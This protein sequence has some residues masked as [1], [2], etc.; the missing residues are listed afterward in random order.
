MAIWLMACSAIAFSQTQ[1]THINGTVYDEQ[2]EPISYVNVYIEGTIEG[3]SSGEDGAFSFTTEA[4]GTVTLKASFIGYQ[5]FSVKDEVKNLHNLKIILKSEAKNLNEVV[6]YAGNYQLKSASTMNKSNAV[7][8]VSTAGSEGD[9]YKSV[10]ML[11][12]T[13][14]ADRDGRLIVRGG[15]SRETQTYIDDMHVLSPYTPAFGDVGSRGRYSPFLF[16]GINF[17]MGGYVPEYSQGLS[18]ILPLYTRDEAKTTKLGIDLM[19]VS[20]GGGGT[21]VWKKASTSFNINYSDMSFYNA[22]FAPS[23]KHLWKKPYRQ[24]SG[25]NQFRFTLGKN[26]YLKTYFGYDHTHFTLVQKAPFGGQARDVNFGENNLYFNST[27]RK[28]FDNGLSLFTGVAYSL[29]R[30]KI[31]NGRAIN[32]ALRANEQEIHLKTK[33]EKRFA[34]FY[35]L[36]AGAESF[37]K[38]YD[39]TYNHTEPFSAKLNHTI[40]GAFVSNDFNLTDN[41]FLNL[42]SRIEHTS[43]SQHWQLLPRAALGFKWG[44]VTL[45]GVIGKYQQNADNEALL[46]N[47]VLLPEQSTQALIGCYYQNE[48]KIFRAELYHKKYNYLPLKSDDISFYASNGYGYAK[49]IDLFFNDTKFL[50]HWQYTLAYSYTDAKRKFMDYPESVRPP[51][52][53]RHNASIALR[54]TNWSIRSIIGIS[55]RFASG[56]PYHNPNQSGFMNAETPTYNSLDASWIILPSKRVIVYIGFANILNRTNVYGYVFNNTQSSNGLYEGSPLTQQTN[57]GLYIGCF[58]S[59]GKNAAYNTSNF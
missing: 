19:N 55:N 13:Q 45:S 56:R 43:L 35:K 11:P 23:I 57:Q 37:I 5:T 48:N 54:Y 17:S 3:V 31:D 47:R 6:V 40:S 4:Q 29:N 42:S 59:L 38:R 12:G 39:F 25:Q 21:I 7:D 33:A 49:G 1:S 53:M 51:F 41:L 22:V 20:V 34:D 14:V 24:L 50:K 2:G 28:K 32:D 58:I 15:S 10:S 44:D 46:Y 18:A 26:Y 9:L 8:L 52:A 36:T 30:Q 27:L 16:E